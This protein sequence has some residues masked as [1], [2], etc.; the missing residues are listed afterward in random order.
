MKSFQSKTFFF[1][2][3]VLGGV[4]IFSSQTASAQ[5]CAGTSLRYVVR[6]AKGVV[7]DPAKAFQAAR[8]SEIEEL[9]NAPDVITGA[10]AG[11]VR[12]IKWFR[13]CNFPEPVHATLHLNGKEMVLEFR[14]PRF[15][16]YESRRFLVDSIPFRA[17]HYFIDLSV[18]GEKT[19]TGNRLGEFYGAKKWSKMNSAKH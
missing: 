14:M 16:E 9:K 19:P 12:V 8:P 13:F 10:P 3:V 17:G 5:I 6:E 11:P 18:E 15:T 2:M 4:F 7:I 1:V